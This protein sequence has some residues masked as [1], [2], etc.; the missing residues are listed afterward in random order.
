MLICNYSY[1]QYVIIVYASTQ[2]FSLECHLLNIRF[3]N[4]CCHAMWVIAK[5][6]HRQYFVQEV[7]QLHL[8]HV[9][10]YLAMNDFVN[11]F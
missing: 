4:A 7:I 8:D 1:V 10:R 6:F 9:T 5:P 3:T 2:Q 11:H